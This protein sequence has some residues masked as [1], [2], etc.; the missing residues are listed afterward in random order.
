[1]NSETPIEVLAASRAVVVDDG[2]QIRLTLYS[3]TGAVASVTLDPVRAV[4]LAQQLIAAA[5]PRLSSGAR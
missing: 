3:E 2:R 1:V 5:L 4:A